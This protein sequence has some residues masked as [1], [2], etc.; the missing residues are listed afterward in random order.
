MPAVTSKIVESTIG[1]KVTE[2][3]GAAVAGVRMD[4]QK[5]YAGVPQLLQ[6]FIN[7][8]NPKAWI[9]IKNKIDYI[10]NNLDYLFVTLD[11]EAPF[12][13]EIQKQVK[14]GKKVFFKPNLVSGG[15][16]SPISHG[17]GQGDTTCTEWSFIAALMR[18]F[19]DKLNIEYSEMA[20][21]DAASSNPTSATIYS[22]YYSKGRKITTQAIFE[23]R[24]GDFYGGYGF[25]FVRKYLAECLPEGH[26]DNPMNGYEESINGK[27]IPPGRAGNRLMVYDLN[28]AGLSK[29][30]TVP[31]PQGANFKEVTLHKA[32]LGGDPIDP[33]DMKDY[34]GCVLVNVPKFKI[35]SQD[36]LTNAIKNLGIGLYPQ[37]APSDDHP[38]GTHWK[39]SYPYNRNP[40]LKAKVPHQTWWPEIDEKTMLPLRD[41][42]G[43]LITKKTKGFPGTQADVIR[44]TQDQGIFMLHIVDAIEAINNSHT[45]AGMGIRVNE[46]FVWASLDCVA[47]DTLCARNV[48]N[49]LPMA[50]GKRLQKENDWQTEFAHIVPAA[51]IEGNAIVTG[52]DYDSPLFRYNLYKYCEERGVGQQ[53]YHVIG[54]DSITNSPLA[55]LEGHLGRIDGEKFE[56]IIEKE[57]WHNPGS[58]L[59]DLQKTAFTYLQAHDKLYGTKL[60]QELIDF[61]DENGD[62]VLDYDEVGK[63]GQWGPSTR[64]AAYA[65]SLR[66]DGKFGWLK[67]G[68]ISRTFST[69]CTRK[70]WNADGFD[71]YASSRM[72]QLLISAFSM[73]RAGAEVPDPLNPPATFGKGK[74]PSW[75]WVSYVSTNS[76]I[77]GMGF[78][79]R[80]DLTG[81]YGTVFQYSDKTQNNGGYTGN[82]PMM[83]N[84]DSL[85]KYLADIAESKRQAL[86]FVLYVP[87]GL[88]KFNGQSVPN[89][90]ETS[91]PKKIF[92]ASFM[93]GK[94]KWGI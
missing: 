57:M 66:A 80:I 62:G 88:G 48:F 28:K 77:W 67:G 70:E 71:F 36:L 78:P 93:G 15:V 21:G 16:I 51:K 44:A 19:H 91:D 24:S 82:V 59:W 49:T 4:V 43:N 3:D 11:N 56:E 73:S 27:Y 25:Y 79:R 30:R 12:A 64:S 45:G 46:G 63:K 74:W 81:L 8:N 75:K 69:K 18:W 40:A 76:T 68:F 60:F 31:V 26:K 35:H 34:P 72:A 58:F 2:I 90:E 85:A 17:P 10:Y 33:K 89:I 20:I 53:K 39:Y 13:Q 84:Q 61:F 9:E 50:E 37:E 55:S 38:R 14:E 52:Q 1:K 6:D 83:S 7:N 54:W 41:K 5:A 29:G 94:E 65:S 86:D 22:Q 42:N 32:I 92:T 23:G 87:V 47:L